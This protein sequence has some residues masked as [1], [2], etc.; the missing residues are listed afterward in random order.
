MERTDLN[1]WENEC[2]LTCAIIIL[3]ATQHVETSMIAGQCRRRKSARYCDAP[4][5]CDNQ[6]LELCHYIMSKSSNKSHNDGFIN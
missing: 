1:E 4:N 3:G 6:F 2:A 5:M